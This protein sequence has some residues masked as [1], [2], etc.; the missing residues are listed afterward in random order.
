MTGTINKATGHPSGSVAS[1]H[2]KK[3]LQGGKVWIRMLNNNKWLMVK[4]SA[5]CGVNPQKT[6]IVQETKKGQKTD[7]QLYGLFE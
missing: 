4:M 2:E 1:L 7:N 5:S 6:G 3:T